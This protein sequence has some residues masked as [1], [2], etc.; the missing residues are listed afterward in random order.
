MEVVCRPAGL[1]LSHPWGTLVWHPLCL[2]ELALPSQLAFPRA[3]HH[4]SRQQEGSNRRPYGASP[5]HVQPSRPRHAPE[6]RH[7]HAC[8]SPRLRISSP[9]DHGTYS[10]GHV[11]RFVCGQHPRRLLR[12]WHRPSQ[13]CILSTCPQTVGYW[14]QHQQQVEA[15]RW[16]HYE[17]PLELLNMATTAQDMKRIGHSGGLGNRTR[18]ISIKSMSQLIIEI[19]HYQ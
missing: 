3:F 12:V 13:G 6:C 16:S 10:G 15:Q 7:R 8:Q 19:L 9:R 18:L 17:S 5:L 2:L 1:Q 11:C 4:A 14:F